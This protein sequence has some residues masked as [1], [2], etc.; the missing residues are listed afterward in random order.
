[1]CSA[2]PS[3]E[4]M[5]PAKGMSA[6]L[7]PWLATGNQR[8]YALGRLRKALGRSILGLMARQ[9]QDGNSLP[10]LGSAQSLSPE[11]VVIDTGLFAFGCWFPVCRGSAGEMLSV[12]AW[13]S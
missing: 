11:W 7:A 3:F 6:F 12:S 8:T 2:N 1:M 4:E 10:A 5:R 13:G 9:E